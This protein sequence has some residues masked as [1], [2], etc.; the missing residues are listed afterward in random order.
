MSPYF[1]FWFFVYVVSPFDQAAVAGPAGGHLAAGRLSAGRTMV[2]VS[3]ISIRLGGAIAVPVSGRTKVFVTS[4]RGRAGL[5]ENR[6]LSA[7][8]GRAGL[9]GDARAPGGESNLAPGQLRPGTGGGGDDAANDLPDAGWQPD[10]A[11]PFSRG[12]FTCCGAMADAG[13]RRRHPDPDPVQYQ[14]GRGSVE[15]LRGAGAGARKRDRDRHWDG[16]H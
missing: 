9:L 8:G 3:G 7:R 12:F 13:G 15:F 14:P 16:G 5:E 1:S 10:G 11:L 4:A 6:H 2:G